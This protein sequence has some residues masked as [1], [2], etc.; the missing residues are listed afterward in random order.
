MVLA[1]QELKRRR[2]ENEQEGGEKK[3]GG[4][5]S[6]GNQ[7]S[8]L[9]GSEES[10]IESALLGLLCLR[11]LLTSVKK[12]VVTREG[13]GKVTECFGPLD[14]GLIH[15]Y[16]LFYDYFQCPRLLQFNEFGVHFCLQS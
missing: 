13:F 9:D 8:E 4:S 11:H 15:R 3:H 14:E 12:N 10:P 1:S 7:E 6:G 5:S 2:T 16:I